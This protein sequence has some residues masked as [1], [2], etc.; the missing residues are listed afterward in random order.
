MMDGY[1]ERQLRKL[2]YVGITGARHR[3]FTPHVAEAEIIGDFAVPFRDVPLER[4]KK[5]SSRFSFDLICQ[6]P[7]LESGKTQER[8]SFAMQTVI[9]GYLDKVK[10]GRKQ[11]HRNLAVFPLLSG[12]TTV[13]DY[14][15]LD[16][17]LA[18]GVIEVTEVSQGGTVPE[19]KLVN[20]S[21]TMVLILDGEELVGA[22]QNRIVNM[23]ILIQAKSTTVIPVG[24][25]EQGRWHYRSPRFSSEERIMSPALRAMKAEHVSRSVRDSGTF[26]SDQG[27]IWDELSLKADRLAAESPTMAMADLY[28]KERSSLSDYVKHFRPVEVQVGAVFLINGKVVG[29]DSFGRP[30]TLAKV[31][32][33]LVESYALDAVEWSEPGSDERPSGAEVRRFLEAAR[34]A[35]VESHSSVGLGTDCR[36]ESGRLAGFALVHE[37]QLLHLSVFAR[38]NGSSRERHGSRMQRFSRRRRTH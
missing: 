21:P 3:L 17:A 7:V 37:E 22:K 13:L 6:N 1:S 8:G 11:S 26:R 33:K 27:R 15:T 24:C 20:K 9:Q 34:A 32:R 16:E 29:L 36:M 10:I 31:F 25:V 35:S 2:V 19:L 18:G 23:T 14:M 12:Y 28:Q 38:G 5:L 4:P 30:E